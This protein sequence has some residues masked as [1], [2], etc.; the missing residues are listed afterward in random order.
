MRSTVSVFL[1]TLESLQGG[2]EVGVG[3]DDKERGG[4]ENPKVVLSQHPVARRGGESDRVIPIA[5]KN[6]QMRNVSGPSI[7]LHLPQC[8]SRFISSDNRFQPCEIGLVYLEQS[9]RACQSRV[10]L[11]GGGP[12]RLQLPISTMLVQR[13]EYLTNHNKDIYKPRRG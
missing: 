5:C 11:L 2:G 10:Y 12:S 6:W 3:F 4:K 9:R 1:G 13:R 7:D 8:R